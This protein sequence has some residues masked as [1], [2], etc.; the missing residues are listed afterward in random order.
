MLEKEWD[1]ADEIQESTDTL[2]EKFESVSQLADQEL[3]SREKIQRIIM[4]E[5]NQ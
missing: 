5:N 1:E 3:K 2:E 4:N